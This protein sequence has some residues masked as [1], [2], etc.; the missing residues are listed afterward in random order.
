MNTGLMSVIAM[1]GYVA[2]T[3]WQFLRLRRQLGDQGR[4]LLFGLGFIAVAFHAGVLM[5]ELVTS[6]GLNFGFFNASSLVFW[7]MALLVLVTAVRMPVENLGL[8]VFPMAA[9]ALALEMLLPSQHFLPEGASAT[10][11]LHVLMSIVAYSMLSV[12]A[13]QAIL[14]AVQDKHLRNHHPGGFVRMLPPLQTMEYLLFRMIGLGFVVM[15]MSLISGF[16]YLD[17]MF[18]QHLVHKT[19]LS[20]IAW[21]FFAVLLWGRWKFGWRGKRAIRV[22]LSGFGSLLLA[23]LGSKLV[24]ELVLGR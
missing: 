16:L 15:S 17:D 14:L 22:T 21:L 24:L 12:A 3:G 10:L 23:Y 13:L 7:L 19:V 5:Q 2:V 11:R 9:L 20:M 1:A 4:G 18:A 8:A 6:E